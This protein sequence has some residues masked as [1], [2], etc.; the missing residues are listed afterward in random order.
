MRSTLFALLALAAALPVAAQDTHLI[1]QGSAGRSRLTTISSDPEWFSKTIDVDFRNATLEDAIKKILDAAK[2]KLDKID[3]QTKGNKNKLTLKLDA[4]NVRDALASVSRLYGAQ[5]YV[6]S[7]DGKTTVELRKR[8]ADTVNIGGSFSTFPGMTGFGGS[9][10]GNSSGS[11]TSII[12][13]GSASSSVRFKDLPEKTL[14]I[15]VKDGSARDVIKQIGEK[16]GIDY[17][18]EE[19]LKSDSKLSIKMKGVSVGNAL[20]NAASWLGGG[21]KAEKKGDK[22]KVVFSKKYPV[23]GPRWMTN[24]GG[25]GQVFTA[26]GPNIPILSD[27][28]IIGNLFRSTPSLS[29]RLS[30]DKK[31]T[32]VRECFKELLKDADL[33]YALADDLPS[34]AKSFTFSN[35]P[36]STALDMI[37]ESI[38]VGWTAE[39]GPDGKPIVRIGK[40]Y[41]NRIRQSSQGSLF[42]SRSIGPSYSRTY[43]RPVINPRIPIDFFLL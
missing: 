3:D 43:E 27:L 32:D 23:P 22:V 28:P 10:G 36:L 16:A 19:G 6:L 34:D 24:P 5:A 21:W 20:D 26:P 18:I 12:V 2:V 38:E 40:R 1:V 39:Q 29:K 30:L 17:E 14:D 33:S 37:C 7:E 8:T 25:R 9:L 42:N 4:V 15:E 11:T 31:N 41:K 35:V 13:P